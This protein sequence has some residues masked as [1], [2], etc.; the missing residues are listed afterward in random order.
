MARTTRVV[1]T[2]DLHGD[3]TEAVSTATITN[4]RARAE[5][6]LCQA[7][8]DDLFGRARGAKNRN[9]K[10]RGAGGGAKGVTKGQRLGSARNDGST[11]AV[12]EWAVT[13]GHAVSSRGR[14]PAG[15]LAAYSEA[16]GDGADA[17]S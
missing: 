8:I 17:T 10:R 4:G 6:D 14:I 11:A 5:L 12:R 1:L 3:D 15:V 13:N 16:H 7:H 2:C 9:S